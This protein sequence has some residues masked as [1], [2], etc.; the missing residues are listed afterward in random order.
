MRML[1]PQPVAHRHQREAQQVGA[2]PVG[3]VQR[4]GVVLCQANTPNRVNGAGL[5]QHAVASLDQ[6]RLQVRLPTKLLIV[7]RH[8]DL[9]AG[10]LPRFG[11]EIA[12][13]TESTK[14]LTALT[15]AEP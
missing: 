2:S 15:L 4:G 1:S 5:D 10:F 14:L 7:A 12:Y 8:Y 11:H 3:R 9:K 6:V 13:F